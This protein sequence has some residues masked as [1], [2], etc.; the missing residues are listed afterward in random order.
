MTVLVALLTTSGIAFGD[1]SSGGRF[2]DD[3]RAQNGQFVENPTG[4]TDIAGPILYQ[5]CLILTESK[6]GAFGSPL[7]SLTVDQLKAFEIDCPNSERNLTISSS[8]Q[9]GGHQTGESVYVTASV[10]LE[11]T[12]TSSVVPY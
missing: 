9:T 8:A 5:T 4:Q 3:C 2:G 10:Y 1:V 12:C 7:T 11:L 6:S